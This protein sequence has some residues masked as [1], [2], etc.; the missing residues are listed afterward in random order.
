MAKLCPL[1]DSDIIAIEEKLV[2]TIFLEPL[3]LG[4]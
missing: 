4:V 1:F 3:E 2:N